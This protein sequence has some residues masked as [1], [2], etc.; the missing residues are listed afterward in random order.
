MRKILKNNMRN[1]I[2]ES[3]LHYITN[4]NLPWEMFNGKTVLVSGASGFLPAYMVETFLYLNET[5][6]SNIK[7][8]GLVRNIKKARERFI[9]YKG[10]KNL[11]LI[12][13]DVCEEIKINEN[14]DY[15]IHAASLATPKVF[16]ENPVGVLSP[17]VIGTANLLKLAVEKKVKNFLFFSTSGVYGYVD[18]S[19][20][21]LKEDCFG[22]LNPADIASCYLESKRMGENMCIAWMH[23]YGVPVKIVR[24]AITYGPGVM[25]ND[26]R[27][28][29]DFISNIVNKQDVALFSDGKAIR[30]FCYIADATLGFFIVILKGEV[31]QAYNVATDYEISIIDLVK[32]L[33][34]KVFPERKLKVVMKADDSKKYLRMDFPRTTVDITK[35]KALGWKL[36]F[37]IE[38]GFKRTV[39]SIEESNNIR[40]ES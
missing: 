13:Q 8:I 26:G 14:I 23:Q 18:Q 32:T 34:E 15:I 21:P 33:V 39:K 11:K 20:Y 30:N 16:Q 24:P 38:E 3:D 17:N 27:S 31:G 40:K 35:L 28:F 4:E 37:P 7:V 36:N 29:A 2:I 6:Q 25:L 1:S 5:R 10:N 12:I 22:S 19:S 9:F